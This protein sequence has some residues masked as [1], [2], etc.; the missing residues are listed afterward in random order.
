MKKI[1]NKANKAIDIIIKA[2]QSSEPS[3]FFGRE[4]DD[5]FENGDSKEIVCEIV[6]KYLNDST[7]KEAVSKVDHWIGIDNWIATYNKIYP[8]SL[9]D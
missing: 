5:I 6:K 9:L 2:S 1:I 3:M 4:F 8:K 7:F